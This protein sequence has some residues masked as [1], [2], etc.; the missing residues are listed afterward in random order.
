MTVLRNRQAMVIGPTPPGTG[1]IAPAMPCASANATSPTSFD[2]PSRRSDPV[3]ADVDHHGARL[4]PV[5]R[6]RSPAGRRPRPEYRRGAGR[7]AGRRLLRV[8]QIV[9]VQFSASSSAAIGLPTILERPSTTASAPPRLRQHFAQQKQAA[10]RRAGNQRALRTAAPELPDILGVKA[11]DVLG[12]SMASIT[13]CG[14]ICFGSGN[15]TRMPSTRSSAL[16]LR[17]QCQ[18]LG[19]RWWSPAASPENSQCRPRRRRLALVAHIDLAR[20]IVADQHG[21]EARRRR[22]FAP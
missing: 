2:L 12:G 6:A 7:P 4:D 10:I 1:V 13:R 11:V 5:A 9:T 22:R 18:Q 14:S 17:N 21:A 16:S 20:R 3:D 15:C 19:L 8:R